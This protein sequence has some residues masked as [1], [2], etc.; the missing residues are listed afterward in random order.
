[1][2]KYSNFSPNV[3]YDAGLPA[4]CVAL[5]EEVVERKRVDQEVK[6][7]EIAQREYLRK[8]ETK[9][10]ERQHQ[11]IVERKQLASI[12][13]KNLRALIESKSRKSKAQRALKKYQR[14]VERDRETGKI[15]AVEKRKNMIVS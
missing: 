3:F 14:Q 7:R 9:D 5:E 8:C 6:A 13:Q 2:A 10:R 1:M 12:A 4:E 11:E 15:L